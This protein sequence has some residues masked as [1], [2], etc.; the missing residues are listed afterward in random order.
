[1]GETAEHAK[2]DG[3]AKLTI[4]YAMLG[5]RL[6]TALRCVRIT[7]AFREKC[8]PAGWSTVQQK[9]RTPVRVA[10]NHGNDVE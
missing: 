8:G 5:R 2:E 7:R 10:I 4:G 6:C 1:M 9:I 3:R